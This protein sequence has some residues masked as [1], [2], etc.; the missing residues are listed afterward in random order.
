MG[1]S[2]VHYIE[3][4][5]NEDDDD[6]GTGQDNGQPSHLNAIDNAPL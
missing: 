3:V 6:E 1:K 4:V 2:K 5:S